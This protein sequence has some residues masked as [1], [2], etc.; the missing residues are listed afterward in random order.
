M[1]ADIRSFFAPKGGAA[2]KK[3]AAKEPEEP[4]KPKRGKRKV[5]EDSEDEDEAFEEAPPASKPAQKKK[6]MY[7]FLAILYTEILLTLTSGSKKTMACLYLPR[8]SLP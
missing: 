1:P 8:S 7:D 6:P 5:V 2:P 4:A 3:P